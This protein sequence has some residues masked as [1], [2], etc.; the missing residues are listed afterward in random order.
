[1][2]LLA[3]CGTGLVTVVA[4]DAP[5]PAAA[6]AVLRPP[7]LLQQRRRHPA[8]S[9]AEPKEVV[10]F[11]SRKGGATDVTQRDIKPGWPNVKCSPTTG[12][13]LWY[14][15]PFDGTQPMGKMPLMEKIPEGKAVVKPRSEKLAL[16]AACGTG[17][18][19][20]IVPKGFPKDNRPV[21]IPTMESHAARAEGLPARPRP[22]LVPGLPPPDQAQHAGRSLW[23]HHQHGPAAAAVRQVPRRQAARLARRHPRQAHR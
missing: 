14:G 13:A 16:L 12:A 11:E 22:H 9:A 2:V 21:P 1:V 19:N 17:C 6:S 5:K 18:H 10:C 20:G 23:R 7:P 15:D 8:A 3:L 4:Q